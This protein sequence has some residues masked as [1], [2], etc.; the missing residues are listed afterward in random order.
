MNLVVGNLQAQEGEKIQ[1]FL[2][3]VN[4]DIEVPCTLINGSKEGKT[5]VITGGTHG[6]EYPGIEAA[7][8]LAKELCPKDVAGNIVILHPLNLPAFRAKLQYVGP[9]DGKN[10]NRE[11]HLF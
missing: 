11:F 6:G 2:K 8:Q 10:L 9:F 3:I 5:V 1:G 4:T 7:I